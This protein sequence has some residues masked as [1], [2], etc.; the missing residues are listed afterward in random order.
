VK[1]WETKANKLNKRDGAW[2][3]FQR[4][5]A[6]GEPFGLLMGIAE[7]ESVSL[8]VRMKG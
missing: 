2:V 3:G 1:Y 6:K 5:I 8:C 4:S 7:T